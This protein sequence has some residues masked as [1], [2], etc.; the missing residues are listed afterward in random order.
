MPA[1]AWVMNLTGAP[2]SPKADYLRSATADPVGANLTPQRRWL[3]AHT[4]VG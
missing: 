1:T 4:P 2:P 3:F